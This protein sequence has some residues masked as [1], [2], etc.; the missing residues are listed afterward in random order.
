MIFMTS[1]MVGQARAADCESLASLLDRGME[2]G[3]VAEFILAPQAGALTPEDTLCLRRRGAPTEVIVAAFSVAPDLRVHLP[4]E[5]GAGAIPVCTELLEGSE[6]QLSPNLAAPDTLR[7][8]LVGW[9]PAGKPVDLEAAAGGVAGLPGGG[10]AWT[11]GLGGVS[12]SAGWTLRLPLALR[13]LPGVLEGYAV[14]VEEPGEPA[15]HL[16]FLLTSSHQ[17]PPPEWGL[18]SHDDGTLRFGIPGSA[19]AWVAA[20]ADTS[21]VAILRTSEAS[22]IFAWGA[23]GLRE[24][25]AR[26][27]A[28]TSLE[29]EPVHAAWPA[30]DTLFYESGAGPRALKVVPR[31]TREPAVL[32]AAGAWNSVES[33]ASSA[34]L[35]LVRTGAGLVLVGPGRAPS[36]VAPG[37]AWF[38][39][40][41]SP[42]GR[43]V[44]V[45]HSR[46]D[47]GRE[48]G[49]YYGPVE[50]AILHTDGRPM[51]PPRR[52]VAV[53]GWD[54]SRS[55]VE[56]NGG[57]YWHDPS[58]PWLSVSNCRECDGWDSVPF[59]YRL[60]LR[61]GLFHGVSFMEWE[62]LARGR[63]PRELP[64]AG[65]QM[66]VKEQG[67]QVLVVAR[68]ASRLLA[69]L[70]RPRCYDDQ[71]ADLSGHG[72]WWLPDRRHAV[73]WVPFAD[74]TGDRYDAGPLFLVDLYGGG[75]PE[76]IDPATSFPPVGLY[77]ERAVSPDG[78]FLILNARAVV[79][80]GEG[81]TVPVQGRAL[82]W[83]EL[84]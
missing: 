56:G 38:A 2:A 52:A 50:F 26:T 34:P 7:V 66:E 32:L 74:C 83:I 4:C 79:A 80:V 81:R 65:D 36:L 59:K 42:D 72:A 70:D 10:Q 28:T 11:A 54:G 55:D 13:G 23:G 37:G 78:R 75:D 84:D 53:S 76:V 47:T 69:R 41:L 29:G 9:S 73:V 27:G 21:E 8:R 35:A 77:D 12:S 44:A 40:A 71:L 43:D 5:V 67:A 16:P 39:S 20:L 48:S 22:R 17:P 33:V 19:P 63:L 18:L 31:N 58:G 15:V 49:A 46:P 6:I 24:V 1:I 30:G 62:I 64:S 82:D 57:A 45:F 3:R 61:T 60:D 25:D 51:E 14:A 68:Q